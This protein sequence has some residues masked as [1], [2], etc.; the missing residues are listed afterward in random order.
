MTS[1]MIHTKTFKISIKPKYL[2]QEKKKVMTHLKT[3][4]VIAPDISENK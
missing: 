1:T 2:I 4:Q 3:V